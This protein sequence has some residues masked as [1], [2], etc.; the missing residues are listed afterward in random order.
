[1]HEAIEEQCQVNIGPV[2]QANIGV[3]VDGGGNN[4]VNVEQIKI[5][6]DFII[7]NLKIIGKS[8]VV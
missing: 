3:K 4:G 2:R 6:F 1:M 7:L 5:K 8:K